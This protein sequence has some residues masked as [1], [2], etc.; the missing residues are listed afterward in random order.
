VV[1]V[2]GPDGGDVVDEKLV[3][4]APSPAE[5]VDEVSGLAPVVVHIHDQVDDVVGSSSELDET[6]VES[7]TSEST[8]ELV[9]VEVV[10]ADTVVDIISS[11]EELVDDDMSVELD[12]VEELALIQ[13]SQMLAPGY[14]SAGHG[15][16]ELVSVSLLSVLESSSWADTTERERVSP[17]HKAGETRMD[18]MLNE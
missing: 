7:A 11:T 18:R 14:G 3:T 5:D 13:S 6:V 10:V 15:Q 8:A 9:K 1:V 12:D 16:S 2:A 17:S 4:T